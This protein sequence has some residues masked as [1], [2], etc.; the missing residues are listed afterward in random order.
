MWTQGSWICF[1]GRF[2]ASSACRTAAEKKAPQAFHLLAAAK[3]HKLRR[4]RSLPAAQ[5][6]LDVAREQRESADEIWLLAQ[7]IGT[8]KKLPQRMPAKDVVESAIAEFCLY[9][10]CFGRA[11]FAVMQTYLF[12]KRPRL[13]ALHAGGDDRD[14]VH[15]AGLDRDISADIL[16]TRSP[17]QL[18]RSRNVLDAHEAIVVHGSVFEWRSYQT[19]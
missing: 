10:A 4:H 8:S 14:M 13:P 5:S 17:E 15:S 7:L 18:A 9:R 2:A 1:Q 12:G 11:D 3:L 16:E 6:R 19:Q